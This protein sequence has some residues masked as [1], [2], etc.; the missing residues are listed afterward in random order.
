M[1]YTWKFLFVSFLY[2]AYNTC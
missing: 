2:D 1:D